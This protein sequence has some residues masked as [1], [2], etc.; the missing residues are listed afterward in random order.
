[1]LRLSCLAFICSVVLGPAQPARAE[2]GADPTPAAFVR[3][4][5]HRPDDP[6]AGHL[7][8][9]RAGC[10]GAQTLV[11]GGD[12]RGG[13]GQGALRLSASLASSPGRGPVRFDP[14]T[15]RLELRARGYL[16]SPARAA[17]RFEPLTRTPMVAAAGRDVL[18]V[19][20][21]SA[22][23]PSLAVREPA[24]PAEALGADASR[25]RLYKRPWLWAGIA[26][27]VGSAALGLGLGL[28]RR[29]VTEAA[30]ADAPF[31]TA[32]GP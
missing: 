4:V 15:Q 22:V 20:L 28:K 31:A 8:E 23:A 9:A 10:V 27:F 5:D 26:L 30:V 11:G 18:R 1:M 17:L 12:A 32:K 25:Q 6:R 7:A 14:A 24:G 16:G 21:A 13:L 19:G 3:A 29:T 2:S